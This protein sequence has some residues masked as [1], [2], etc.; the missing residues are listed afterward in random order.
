LAILLYFVKGGYLPVDK[1]RAVTPE[2]IIISVIIS[3]LMVL[4]IGV[5]LSLLLAVQN[6]SLKFSGAFLYCCLGLLTSIA[7]PSSLSG[8]VVKALV[9][10]KK[11]KTKKASVWFTVALDRMIGI[12]GLGIVAVF[13]IVTSLAFSSWATNPSLRDKTI[14]I[15]MISLAI[16]LSVFAL[17]MFILFSKPWEW[18]YL[19]LLFSKL[20]KRFDVENLASAITR[21]RNSYRT[22]LFALGL[23]IINHLL[24]VSVFKIICN[25]F[26]V[27]L[28]FLQT[29]SIISL[30]SFVNAIPFSPGN[31]GTGDAVFGFLFSYM[32]QP[33]GVMVSVLARVIFYTPAIIAL[34]YLKNIR[35]FPRKYQN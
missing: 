18:R 4:L 29:G 3:G 32:G 22:L 25:D 13:L 14:I 9:L 7:I 27:G 5:R 24:R 15:L 30:A 10:A 23:S 31:F 12:L 19:S 35:L 2:T 20:K 16:T 6:V 21:S 33:Y 26:E 1:L 11:N 8:D 28:S 34:Y 17:I